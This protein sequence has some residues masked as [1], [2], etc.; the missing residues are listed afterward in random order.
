MKGLHESKIVTRFWIVAILLLALG[1][2]TIK[3]R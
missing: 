3:L 2:S 1:L